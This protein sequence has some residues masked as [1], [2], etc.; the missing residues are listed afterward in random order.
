L[1]V[2]DKHLIIIATWCY[3]TNS[4]VSRRAA[5]QSEEKGSGRMAFKK[6]LRGVAVDRAHHNPYELG[7]SDFLKELGGSNERAIVT[8]QEPAVE[9]ELQW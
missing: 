3:V 4:I 5:T 9:N 7:V 2:V 1:I 8:T 6:L